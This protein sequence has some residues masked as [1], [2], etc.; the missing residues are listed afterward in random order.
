MKNTIPV[1]PGSTIYD[2]ASQANVSITTVSRYLNNPGKVNVETGRKI[3]A[4]MDRLARDDGRLALR[5]DAYDA[6]AGAGDFYRKC[7][8][9]QCGGIVYRGVPLLLF[10]KAWRREG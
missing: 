9:R 8:F 6:P 10:E 1:A 4:A 3:Q 2:V 5:F 7:G